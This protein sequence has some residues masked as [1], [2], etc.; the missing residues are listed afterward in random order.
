MNINFLQSK[1]KMMQKA[2]ED[3]EKS[4]ILIAEVSEKESV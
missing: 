3:V 4:A 2:M 1:K